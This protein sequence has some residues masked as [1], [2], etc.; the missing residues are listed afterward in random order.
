[1]IAAVQQDKE[2]L[3]FVDACLWSDLL[4]ATVRYAPADTRYTLDPSWDAHTAAAFVSEKFYA[5]GKLACGH[6]PSAP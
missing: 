6:A 5:S 1:M 3:Q 2:A 4:A